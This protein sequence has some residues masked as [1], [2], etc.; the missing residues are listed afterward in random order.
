M[1]F[2]KI[3]SQNVESDPQSTRSEFRDISS[4]IFLDEWGTIR[5]AIELFVQRENGS[6]WQPGTMNRGVSNVVR[7]INKD[8]IGNLIDAQA[9]AI[10]FFFSLISANKTCF[11]YFLFVHTLSHT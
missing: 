2:L 7:A 1:K 10:C 5:A 4:Y 11:T 3:Y 6:R 8:G 9:R